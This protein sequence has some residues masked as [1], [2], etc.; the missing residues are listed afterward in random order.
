MNT[1]GVGNATS[2]SVSAAADCLFGVNVNLER[3]EFEVITGNRA[4][5]LLC[6][7]PFKPRHKHDRGIFSKSGES[8]RKRT[9][10]ED[11]R[12]PWESMG[13][14]KRTWYRKHR[15]H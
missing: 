5:V 9:P 3:A 6:S 15:W 7:E 2:Q 4:T 13:I 11:D 14:S 12:R 10:L 1:W 8:R